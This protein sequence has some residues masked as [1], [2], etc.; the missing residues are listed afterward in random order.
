MLDRMSSISYSAR[1]HQ[2]A[3]PMHLDPM[4]NTYYQPAAASVVPSCRSKNGT[5]NAQ[6]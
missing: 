2:E 3:M 4:L 1:H 5:L 6:S